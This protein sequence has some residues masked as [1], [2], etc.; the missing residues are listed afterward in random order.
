[1]RAMK[2]ALLGC[3]EQDLNEEEASKSDWNGKTIFEILRKQNGESVDSDASASHRD[4][5]VVVG[6]CLVEHGDLASSSSSSGLLQE[7]GSKTAD[8][9]AKTSNG[10]IS[11]ILQDGST[12]SLRAMERGGS[13]EEEQ[14]SNTFVVDDADADVDVVAE[15]VRDKTER[16]KE[17]RN[18]SGEV[19]SRTG[20]DLSQ[21]GIAQAPPGGGDSAGL[22]SKLAG[23]ETRSTGG[24][25]L[26]FAL[27][28]VH[29]PAIL[30]ACYCLAC[31]HQLTGL[32]FATSLGILMAMISV[33]AMFFF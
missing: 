29:H 8:E 10:E 9:S 26:S 1:M 13:G 6:R 27:T 5:V 7:V 3:S 12:A 22:G 18:S 19:P 25:G 20:G 31:L 17:T 30:A 33:V 16:E 32:D 21:T 23:G 24:T 15:G 2:E 4:V 14:I 28:L 11:S